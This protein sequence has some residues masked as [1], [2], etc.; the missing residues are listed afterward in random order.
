[1]GNPSK[2]PEVADGQGEAVPSTQINWT[3]DAPT[4]S[5]EVQQ[6]VGGAHGH[7]EHR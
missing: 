7:R 5:H 2:S 6:P 3:E 4:P 1:M